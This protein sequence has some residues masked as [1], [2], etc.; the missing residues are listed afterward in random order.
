[1]KD[2]LLLPFKE[3]QTLAVR[4]LEVAPLV[5]R[6]T[7]RQ[8]RYIKRLRA[9]DFIVPQLVGVTSNSDFPAIRSYIRRIH[10][11]AGAIDP[12]HQDPN[13]TLFRVERVGDEQTAEAIIEKFQHKQ[14]I[15]ILPFRPFRD[16]GAAAQ[17]RLLEAIPPEQDVDGQHSDHFH[18]AATA[19]ASISIADHGLGQL[20][21]SSIQEAQRIAIVGDGPAVG[22]PIR[23]ILESMGQ[24]PLT[25]TH[26]TNQDW[27]TRLGEFD[28]VFGAAGSRRATEIITPDS[29][30]RP[31]AHLHQ[32]RPLV[33][34][35]AAY[36]RGY[37]NTPQ[38]NLH[39]IFTDEAYMPG[40]DVDCMVTR[41]GAVG[42][43]T[44]VQIFD[45]T[46]EVP[47]AQMTAVFDMAAG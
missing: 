16:E 21:G 47:L 32:R 33:I 35:D 1:V 6:D 19:L 4:V 11:Q 37:D 36:D 15:G 14:G 2:N 25:I 31:G 30:R 24:E 39:R 43:K 40:P 8:Q 45:N 23:T 9:L 5:Q 29:V 3:D 34:V 28:V 22:R 38:G 12:A 20:D 10:M 46:F 27:M 41:L 7:E 17:I 13:D 18:K 44:G 42:A 26:N